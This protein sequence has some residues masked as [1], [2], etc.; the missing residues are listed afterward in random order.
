MPRK[1]T[2]IGTVAPA[3]SFAPTRIGGNAPAT[4]AAPKTVAQPRVVPT[5]VVCKVP[6]KKVAPS[7]IVC[8]GVPAN[9]ESRSS[10]ASEKPKVMASPS[11]LSAS[12]VPSTSRPYTPTVMPGSRWS[13]VTVSLDEL[14]KRFPTR[15]DDL[16]AMVRRKIATAPLMPDA[17]ME[18]LR[19]GEKQQEAVS[20][21]I[22]RR[23]ELTSS[24]GTRL[25]PALLGQLKNILQ[26]LLD[27]MDSGLFKRS[28]SR[29]WADKKPEVELL[30]KRL[31]DEL[32]QLRV[33]SSRMGEL[34]QDI[35]KVEHQL[36]ALAVASIYLEE[37]FSDNA[38][39][40]SARMTSIA[41]THALAIEQIQL[42]ELEGNQLL[43]LA[44]L[45][46]DG[47]LVRLPSVYSLLAQASNRLNETQKLLLTESLL[48]LSST[49]DKAK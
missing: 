17:P 39:L 24:N 7:A 23:L 25:T 15:S 29:V 9:A 18:W 11:S 41:A 2:V 1:P 21:L 30:E 8:T 3:A 38:T 49:I 47:I 48:E 35:S 36:Q 22:K 31:N 43:Q 20:K 19:F 32:P 14:K 10:L 27:S 4:P 13:K 46:Q 37:V 6:V 33:L 12:P 45:V 40:I 26:E 16:L 5:A 34:A 42:F 44:T 28:T